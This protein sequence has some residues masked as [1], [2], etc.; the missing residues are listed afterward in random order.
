[1]KLRPLQP[2]DLKKASKIVGQ[3]YSK[4]FEKASF[5]EMEAMFKNYVAKPHY[6]VAEDKDEIIGLAGYM[7]SWID[8][9]VYDIFWV[10]VTPS[11]QRKGIGFALVK[12]V[13]EIIKKKKASIILLTT[14]KPKFY[15]KKFK[16]KTLTK[17]KNNKYDLMSLKLGK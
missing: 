4:K 16:F 10:N 6:I 13:I 15:A 2:R 5:K 14:S 17:F 7:Q 8:Y 11:H 12:R 1:M 9:N 3:N